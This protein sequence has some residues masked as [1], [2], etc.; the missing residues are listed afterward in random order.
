MAKIPDRHSPS[1]GTVETRVAGPPRSGLGKLGRITKDTR[2]P[3]RRRRKKSGRDTRYGAAG[4]NHGAILRRWLMLGLIVAGFG[5]SGLLVWT[6]LR[7]NTPSNPEVSP[8]GPN[9]DDS[10]TP[11]LAAT[12]AIGMVSAMLKAGSPEALEPLLRPGSISPSD[13]LAKLHAI[14]EEGD[15]FTDPAWLGDFD[16]ICSPVTFVAV[17]K[18]L[19][20]PLLV[21]LTPDHDRNWKIDFEATVGHCDPS[22]SEWIEGRPRE[23]LIRA[24]GRPD[25][26]Y[27]GPFRDDSMWACF[28]FTHPAGDAAL[29]GYCRRDSVQ[30]EAIKMILRRNLLATSEREKLAGQADSFRVTL[31]LGDVEGGV[32]R[33]Y[34]IT[35]II[36]DDWVIGDDSLEEILLR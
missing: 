10:P 16:G 35:E 26:Y 34:R 1:Q 12:D 32:S 8:K 22:F 13:A 7:Q 27:N 28:A 21:T 5:I 30:F 3:S 19:G 25:N 33:Q 24:T 4:A 9:P 6:L 20:A 15:G 2:D 31:R 18:E 14:E 11:S 17:R 23:G 29:Y 36:S